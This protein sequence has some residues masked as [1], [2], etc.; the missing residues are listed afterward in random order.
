MKMRPDYL[1]F[2]AILAVLAVLVA[3]AN[4]KG[5]ERDYDYDGGYEGPMKAQKDYVPER[6][7]WTKGNSPENCTTAA[8]RNETDNR[9]AG[10]KPDK[11]PSRAG[12][13]GD[14]PAREGIK[15]SVA[16]HPC[17]FILCPPKAKE[18]KK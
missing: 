3:T 10:R 18:K 5:F 6:L 13:L 9:S 14:A 16:S 4:S 12:D 15:P 17:L 7:C 2:L 11:S 8:K 1:L